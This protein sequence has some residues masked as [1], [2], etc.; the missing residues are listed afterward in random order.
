MP[1]TT[2]RY[3][4]G[5]FHLDPAEHRLLRE[6]V[7]VGLQ[8]KAFEILCLLVE[9]A[10]RLIKKEEILSRVW[11]DT[12][13]EE[14][15]LNK[16]VSLLRK[17]LGE[18]ATGQSYIET[19]PRVGYRFVATVTIDD[20]PAPA[21]SASLSHNVAST[22]GGPSLPANIE[23]SVQREVTGPPV[24][25]RIS[26]ST[27]AARSL[28]IAALVLFFA[29]AGWYGWRNYAARRAP[30]ERAMLAVLPF[31][32]LSGNPNEDYLSDGL[33][34]EMIAQLGQVQPA[35]LGVIAGTSTIGYKKTK[36]PAA[37]IGRELGAGYLLEG[38][39][40]RSGGRVRVTATLVQA[41]Q[42][43]HL[44]AESYER[45]LT[46]VLTIQREIAEKI[47]HSLF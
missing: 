19:V 10:G 7:E 28:T 2:G 16:N 6:G 38:S 13:V 5:P 25:T 17:A 24:A 12:I 45:P 26:F 8:L 30:A 1:Q 46:D 21:T 4:F 44:W 15:N 35:S 23:S 40:L 18:S 36:E 43:T 14:N 39:V 3:K 27:K 31:E 34:Q 42:Q 47:A 22:N 32:N 29:A 37:Q 41:D 20:V 33:T 9:N 11:P